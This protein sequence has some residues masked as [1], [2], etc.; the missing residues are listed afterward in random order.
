[1]A[2]I[3]VVEVESPPRLAPAAAPRARLHES[4]SLRASI[5]PL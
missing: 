2:A 3:G 5:L 4:L 1:V